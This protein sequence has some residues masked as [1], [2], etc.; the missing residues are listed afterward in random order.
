MRCTG[1]HPQGTSDSLWPVGC[2]PWGHTIHIVVDVEWWVLS[3]SW[4]WVSVPLM[5][6][7]C[8]LTLWSMWH[9]CMAP[10]LVRVWSDSVVTVLWF[11]WTGLS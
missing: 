9:G 2:V 8:I 7:V 10:M 11:G 6:M 4:W 1:V 5:G 3:L